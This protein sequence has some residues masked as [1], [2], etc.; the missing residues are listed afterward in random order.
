MKINIEY[1][2]VSLL[3]SSEKI[4]YFIDNNF[5]NLFLNKNNYVD[6]LNPKINILLKKNSNNNFFI[7]KFY[8]LGIITLICDITLN[9]FLFKI[10]KKTILNIS[11]NKNFKEE[12]GDYLVLPLYT[13]KVN[14][15]QYLYDTIILMLPIKKIDPKIRKTIYNK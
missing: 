14:I 9:K 2:D 11:F 13:R 5:F 15:A 3:S 8:F 4:K 12:S 10:K 6:Y 7:F 1:Y